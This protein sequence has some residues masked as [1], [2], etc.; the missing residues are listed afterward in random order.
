LPVLLVRLF[1]RGPFAWR[2]AY[3]VSLAGTASHVALDGSN[4][5][6]VRYLLPFSEQWFSL[7]TT[8]VVDVWIWA[9][10]LVSV[11]APALGSLVSSEIGARRNSGRTSAILALAF[12]TVYTGARAV[13]RSRAL[14][15][16]DSRVYTGGIPRKTGAFPTAVNPML[17]RGVVEGDEFA[18]VFDVDLTRDFDPHAGQYFFKPKDIPAEGKL[19]ETE[20][21]RTFLGFAEFPLWWT[22]PAPEEE[23]ALRV[24]AIDLRF[25]TPRQPGFVV[26]AVVNARQEV[27]GANFEFGT[28]NIRGSR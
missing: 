9:V 8:A 18:A 24:S 14:A 28:P 5:Y 4:H 1:S 26:S 22:L 10:M 23:G 21:F 17:W 3:L 7:D 25:G 27:T 15:E 19:R 16:L 20:A 11:L 13:L 12:L 6:G 2:A